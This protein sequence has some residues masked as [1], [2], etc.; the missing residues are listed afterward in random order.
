MA[1]LVYY[2]EWLE[3]SFIVRICLRKLLN[4]KFINKGI[5]YKF[6]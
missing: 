6:K 3:V 5:V 4:Q 1:L 2:R